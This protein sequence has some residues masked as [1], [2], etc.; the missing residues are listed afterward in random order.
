MSFYESGKTNQVLNKDND[1][2]HLQNNNYSKEN[3]DDKTT[4]IFQ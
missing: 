1:T 4:T 3:I 2:N